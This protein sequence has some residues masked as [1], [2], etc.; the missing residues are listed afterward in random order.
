MALNGVIDVIWCYYI[1]A[2]HFK[3]KLVACTHRVCD[4]K[5]VKKD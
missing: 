2:P 5:V 4:K 3:V 1:D